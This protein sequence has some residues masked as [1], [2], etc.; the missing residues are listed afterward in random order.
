MT[1][2][3]CRFIVKQVQIADNLTY[4]DTNLHEYDISA[5]V[6]PTCIGIF[7]N[8]MKRLGNPEPIKV[9]SRPAPDSDT[10][11]KFFDY[12]SSGFVGIVDQK[13]VLEMSEPNIEYDLYMQAYVTEPRKSSDTA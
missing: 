9:H 6:P 10:I 5:F 8:A 12:E 3:R 1:R 7:M 4:P 13:L 11:Q 2:Q